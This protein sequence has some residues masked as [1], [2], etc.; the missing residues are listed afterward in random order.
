MAEATPHIDPT[1]NVLD[2]VHAE[3]KYQDAMRAEAARYQ[4]ALRDAETRRLDG[5]AALRD[6]Y[7]SRIAS[8]LRVQVENTSVLLSTQLDRM[9]TTLS[10][11]IAQLERFRWESGGKGLGANAVIAYV[12]AIAGLGVAAIAVIVAYLR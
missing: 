9:T 12:L 5:L 2:L 7:E 6:A 4:D 3:S 10:E 8:L 11:R 1:K